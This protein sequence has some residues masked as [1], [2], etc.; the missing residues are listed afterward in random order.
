MSPTVGRPADTV[1]EIE[2]GDELSL[3]DAATGTALA[4]NRTARDV[5]ALADG[6]SDVDDIVATLAKAYGTDPDSIAADV[7]ATVAELTAAGV[8]VPVTS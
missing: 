8:L 4:L 5:W 1:S 3:F 7:H 2:L 6:E